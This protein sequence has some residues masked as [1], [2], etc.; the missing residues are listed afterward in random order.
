MQNATFSGLSI[1]LGSGLAIGV[2]ATLFTLIGRSIGPVRASL[3][4]NVTGGLVAGTILV[5]VLGI[6]RHQ[7]WNLTGS[8][9]LSAVIAVSIGIFIVIGTT[10]ALQRTGVAMGIATMFLGQM[11][12]GIIVDALGWAG[13]QAVPLDLRRMVG[14]VIMAVAIMLLAPRT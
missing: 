3:V 11:I 2:Q 1:A 6:R 4:L 8:T 12:I 13:G 10:I 9:L 14:L 7:Q 5:V